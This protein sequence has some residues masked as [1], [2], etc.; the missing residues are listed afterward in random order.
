M[1]FFSLSVRVLF[2]FVLEIMLFARKNC[3]CTGC[4]VFYVD[5]TRSNLTVQN[6]RVCPRVF[7]CTRI[8]T[9]SLVKKSQCVQLY[10]HGVCMTKPQLF[11]LPSK[12]IFSFFVTFAPS[13][14]E[15]GALSSTSGGP[16]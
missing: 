14:C 16:R 7:S 1:S 4:T 12:F 15:H 3:C 5:T 6:V 9:A 8:P 11:Q 10:T 2:F 13:A